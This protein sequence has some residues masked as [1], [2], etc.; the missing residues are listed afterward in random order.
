M[1]ST[2][3]GAFPGTVCGGASPLGASEGQREHMLRKQ[4]SLITTWMFYMDVKS[5]MPE[6]ET[7]GS[8]P[9]AGCSSSGRFQ[10]PGPPLSFLE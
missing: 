9:A 4:S 10:P 2:G 3:T 1:L 6:R 7:E 8:E 5:M